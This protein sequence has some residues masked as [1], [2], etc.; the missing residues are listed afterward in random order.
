M[1]WA[2]KKLLIKFVRGWIISRQAAVATFRGHLFAIFFLRETGG[3]YTPT[4]QK[5]IKIKKVQNSTGQ[6]NN[7]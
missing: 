5:I 4:V 1:W 3:V 2:Y 7:F 6:A